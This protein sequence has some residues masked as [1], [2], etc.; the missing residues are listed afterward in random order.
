[1]GPQDQGQ[2]QHV[3]A[4]RDGLDETRQDSIDYQ[5]AFSSATVPVA[6]S[7]ATVPLRHQ[8]EHLHLCFFFLLLFVLAHQT[9]AQSQSRRGP[10]CCHSAPPLTIFTSSYR[11]LTCSTRQATL[12]PLAPI[13]PAPRLSGCLNRRQAACLS[14]TLRGP[15]QRRT[16]PAGGHFVGTH[17]SLQQSRRV[18]WS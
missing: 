17:H 6:F 12:F 10:S 11:A 9:V 8:N 18:V 7:R 2:T 4:P 15:S 13:R 3:I 1:M 14:N 16:I 5:F